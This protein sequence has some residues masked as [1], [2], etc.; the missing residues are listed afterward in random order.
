ML[1]W[2]AITLTLGAM[3]IDLIVLFF[4]A[5]V[6]KRTKGRFR[7]TLIF[8]FIAIF[9]LFIRRILNV[10]NLV[11]I[12]NIEVLD[13]SF[14][15]IVATMFLIGVI[16]LF[17]DVRALTDVRLNHSR[18]TRREN[19]FPPPRRPAYENFERQEPSEGKRRLRVVNGY[20]DFTNE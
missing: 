18:E 7:W 10:L 19:N 12:Y 15:V 6:T 9:I 17:R 2:V 16:Y 3:A 4:L 20:V 14:A 8:F 1:D 13:D 11:S 5:A